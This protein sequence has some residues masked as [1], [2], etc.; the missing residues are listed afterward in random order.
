MRI[1]DS[2]RTWLL[3]GR[4]NVLAPLADWQALPDVERLRFADVV[5]LNICDLLTDLSNDVNFTL[6]K[7]DRELFFG[8]NSFFEANGKYILNHLFNSG[9]AVIARDGS[10]L[11]QLRRD[12]YSVTDLKGQ[13][14]VRPNDRDLDVYVMQ[15]QTYRLC[16]LSDRELCG[17]FLHYLDNV[18]NGSNAVS[19][20]LGCVLIATPANSANAPKTPVLPKEQKDAIEKEVTNGYGSLKRQSNFMLLPRPM[21]FTTV[22]MAGLDQKTQEKARLAILAICDR[23]KVPANQVAIIDANSSKSLSNGSELREGDK[24]KYKSFRRLLNSTFFQMAADL[25]LTIDYVVEGEPKDETTT[26]I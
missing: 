26:T 11:W 15:S 14:I 23:I 17:P 12:E 22:N 24:A 7:G 20:R 19:E 18:I 16:R 2:I 10:H 8:F 4:A 9:F 1:R 6:L 25:G 21:E 13:R 5:F 3:G